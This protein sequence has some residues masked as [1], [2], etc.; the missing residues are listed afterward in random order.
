MGVLV[1]NLINTIHAALGVTILIGLLAR[2]GRQSLI[3]Y[4]RGRAE[5]F[6]EIVQ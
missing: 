3:A 4:Y 5:E 6:C 2:S 1:A